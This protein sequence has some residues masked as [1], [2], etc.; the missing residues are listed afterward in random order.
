MRKLL[1][2][3]CAVSLMALPAAAFDFSF[4][5]GAGGTA[6][7]TQDWTSTQNGVWSERTG[8]GATSGALSEGGSASDSKFRGKYAD[9]SNG[10]P[11]W[12]ITGSTRASSG[13]T[14]M[15]GAETSDN[16]S[17]A[18]A[19]GGTSSSGGYSFGGGGTL[20]FKH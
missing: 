12:S 2:A 16:G 6:G 10:K 17:A 4:Q 5:G 11:K 20:K 3:S 19:G 1:L 13:Q 15:S 18:A 7:M 9:G 14:S 8:P